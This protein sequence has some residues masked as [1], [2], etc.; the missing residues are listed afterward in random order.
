MQSPAPRTAGALPTEHRIADRP[1]PTAPRPGGRGSRT[2]RARRCPS[3]PAAP[4]DGARQSGAPR[5]A[6]PTRRAATT[7]SLTSPWTRDDLDHFR[8]AARERAGLVE[9]HA[10]HRR[11]PL[12]MEAALDEDAAPRGG[13]ERRHQRDRRRD[14][15]RART[16]DDEQHER[17][18]RS[19]SSPGPSRERRHDRDERRQHDDGGRV[20][21]REAIDEG[22]RRRALRL[23]GLDQVD[24]ARKRRVAD[25]AG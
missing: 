22:L 6:P 12:E 11:E 16:R 25:R 1:G 15:E 2:R 5:T 19:T 4:H 9:R 17:R 7:A 10:L 24:D 18:D 23:R 20:D 3:A 13:G 21:P 8:R 14:D